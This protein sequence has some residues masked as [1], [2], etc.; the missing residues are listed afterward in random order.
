M[1]ILVLHNAG[2]TDEEIASTLGISP[3]IV[4]AILYKI[5]SMYRPN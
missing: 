5:Y 1:E 2:Y 3:I 4:A